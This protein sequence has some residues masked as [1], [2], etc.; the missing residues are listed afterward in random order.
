MTR[1][2]KSV[3]RCVLNPFRAK[4][5]A[6][7]HL[8]LSIFYFYF[9]HEKYAVVQDQQTLWENRT[10]QDFLDIKNVDNDPYYQKFDEFIYEK[11]KNSDGQTYLEIGCHFGY[12]LAKFS[13]ILPD[14]KFHGLDIGETNL[15]YGQKNIPNLKNIPLIT[16]NATQ[17]P[18]KNRQFDVVYTV[19]SLTHIDFSIVENAI[20]EM[21]RACN[22]RMLLVEVD[23]R[24]MSFFRK[25]GILAW[26][27]G[28][29]HYYEKLVDDRM[30]LISITPLKD[31]TG[32]PRYTAFEFKRK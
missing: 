26:N 19:V 16:A 28:H 9:R 7:K 17:L 23:H 31:E 12:R 15:R 8:C 24:P 27:Y 20:S 22:H 2:L 1:F 32:H 13:K 3:L 25:L 6:W 18:L 11:L 29:M 5:S 30:E 14:K 4:I 10:E 21:T